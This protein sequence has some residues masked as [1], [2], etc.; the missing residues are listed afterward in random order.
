M[1][2]KELEEKARDAERR[3]IERMQL[4]LQAEKDKREQRE[5]RVKENQQQ[6]Q[7]ER[8]QKWHRIEQRIAAMTPEKSP[9]KR[10][11]YVT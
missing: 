9:A 10:P 2:K 11:K 7:K 1:K 3:R 4:K 8:E 6:I 5:Q